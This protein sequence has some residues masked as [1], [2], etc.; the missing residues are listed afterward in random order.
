[1]PIFPDGF[2]LPVTEGEKKRLN[3]LITDLA[4]SYNKPPEIVKDWLKKQLKTDKSSKDFTYQEYKTA[5][6]IIEYAKQQ[7]NNNQSQ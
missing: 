7:L 2:V 5:V 3:I 1:M 4:Y 6:S